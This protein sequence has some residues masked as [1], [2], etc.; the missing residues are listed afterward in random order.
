M[1]DSFLVTP[2]FFST[3][4]S[5][6]VK[7]IYTC[8]LYITPLLKSLK[9]ALKGELSAK[10]NKVEPR[11]KVQMESQ[12][13]LGL[14]LFFGTDSH[15]KRAGGGLF[16]G[17]RLWL[18]GSR[19]PDCIG[20]WTR[21]FEMPIGLWTGTRLVSVVLLSCCFLLL[22]A[23]VVSPA[24]RCLLY[25]C[26]YNVYIYVCLNDRC[27][28]FMC[29]LYLLS[30]MAGRNRNCNCNWN[31]SPWRQWRA[32]FCTLNPQGRKKRKARKE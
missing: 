22:C 7:W 14:S 15:C 10:V 20:L 18:A 5:A 25:I 30:L 12:K 4:K 32:D 17:G 23:F 1:C 16:V 27:V 31:W 19:K 13:R 9:S 29:A 11:G 3:L 26:I 28:F 8:F 2:M 6:R 24:L 21:V